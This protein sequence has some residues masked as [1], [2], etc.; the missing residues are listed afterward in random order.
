MR[1]K[2][3]LPI[4]C[5]MIMGILL[6]PNTIFGD[7]PTPGNPSVDV[8]ITAQPVLNLGGLIAT[9][10]NDNLIQLD[11]YAGHN[12]AKTMIR[13]KYDSPP[14]NITDGYQV[15]YDNGTQAFDAGANLNETFSTIYYVASAIDSEGNVL[16]TANA[17][18]E[19]PQLTV[20]NGTL[21]Q[22]LP[23]IIIVCFTIIALAS[24][25]RLLL[26]LAGFMIIFY[27]YIIYDTTIFVSYSLQY[28]IA[29]G[30]FGL[31]IIIYG[32]LSSSKRD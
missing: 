18:M 5:L 15:Y 23:L 12:V 31:L 20:L 30:I 9:Y 1:W 21:G 19:S 26:V 24:R 29:I 14:D 7:D 10:I 32:I 11:W 17:T 16:A 22:F 6:C 27:A 4:I 13:A 28:S 3:A 25:W 2:L 8:T